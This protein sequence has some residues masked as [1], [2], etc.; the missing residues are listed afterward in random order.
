[1]VSMLEVYFVLWMNAWITE[2]L[3]VHENEAAVFCMYCIKLEYYAWRTLG[4]WT[5]NSWRSMKADAWK[6]FYSHWM[7]DWIITVCL[8]GKTT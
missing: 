2:N 8:L 5:N 7:N 3:R 6:F 1:M 4:L